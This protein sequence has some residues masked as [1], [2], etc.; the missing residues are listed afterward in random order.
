M[1]FSKNILFQK[2]S[3]E[4]GFVF[5]SL[6]IFK[7][8]SK[9]WWRK[10]REARCY[11]VYIFPFRRRRISATFVTKCTSWAKVGHRMQPSL[12]SPSPGTCCYQRLLTYYTT[13]TDATSKDGVP[14]CACVCVC[15]HGGGG[16]R[17]NR[18]T[19][20]RTASSGKQHLLLLSS[21]AVDINYSYS[22][23]R[24]ALTFVQTY[25]YSLRSC[26]PAQWGCT[27]RAF[28]PCLRFS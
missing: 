23:A 9:S 24:A 27:P 7:N 10:G 28:Q 1:F 17:R 12:P 18:S 5:E 21:S 2:E 13:S 8:C 14:L 26:L 22:A 11:G 3:S 15:L 16:G 20:G 6:I 25:F 4:K 19:V